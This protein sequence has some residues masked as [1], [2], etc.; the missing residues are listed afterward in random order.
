MWL[1]WRRRGV[2]DTVLVVGVRVQLEALRRIIVLQK[3][4][5]TLI[6]IKSCNYI[7][8]NGYW[9]RISDKFWLN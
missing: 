2:F 5:P 6:G 7:K 4:I 1:H 3:V 9:I 8:I